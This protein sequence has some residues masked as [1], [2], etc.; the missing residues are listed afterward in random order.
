MGNNQG[1]RKRWILFSTLSLAGGLLLTTNSGNNVKAD[2]VSNPTSDSET[3]AEQD[4]AN[5]TATPTATPS[6]NESTQVS[7]QTTDN[8]VSYSI[9]YVD[10]TSNETLQSST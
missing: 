5:K 1:N 10:S 9:N 3:V 8:Q 2:T 6:Q 7:D 4:S